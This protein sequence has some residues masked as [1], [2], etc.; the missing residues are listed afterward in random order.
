MMV[1]TAVGFE[2]FLREY[3]S[4][5][6]TL[7]EDSDD[8]AEGEIP[9]DDEEYEVDF[10]VSK[11]VIDGITKY[12]I[13]WKGCGEE[14]DEWQSADKLVNSADL[15]R[16]LRLVSQGRVPLLYGRR[17]QQGG[18]FR[19]CINSCMSLASWCVF[20]AAKG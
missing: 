3:S 14:D 6:K 1:N 16:T 15:S 11:Q 8:E 5:H 20:K 12:L 9:E 19:S 2:N 18:V 4:N 10:I 13:R 7:A 17:R